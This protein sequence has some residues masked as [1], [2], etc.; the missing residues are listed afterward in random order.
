MLMVKPVSAELHS[1]YGVA[2]LFC[3]CEERSN[4]ITRVTDEMAP[5]PRND[6]SIKTQYRRLITLLRLTESHKK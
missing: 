2:G 6:P 1:K 3:H 5:V 4:H